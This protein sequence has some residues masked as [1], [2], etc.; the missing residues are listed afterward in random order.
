MTNQYP[1]KQPHT[2][3]I[4]LACSIMIG[5]LASPTTTKCEIIVDWTRDYNVRD[6]PSFGIR[7][8]AQ[9]NAERIVIAGGTTII[10]DDQNQIHNNWWIGKL[11][12]GLDAYEWFRSYGDSLYHEHAQKVLILNDEIA[13]LG[14]RT[15]IS[16]ASRKKLAVLKL[17]SDGDSLWSRTL[18]QGNVFF[19]DGLTTQDGDILLLGG[20]RT[21]QGHRSFTLFKL[22]EDG[23][24][25]W[26]RD[27]REQDASYNASSLAELQNSDYLITGYYQTNEFLEDNIHR[28]FGLT[29]RIDSDGELLWR[30]IV[31]D[32]TRDVD[33]YVYTNTASFYRSLEISDGSILSCG[34]T[35]L[36]GRMNVDERLWLVKSDEDGVVE[37]SKHYRN[38]YVLQTYFNQ[39]LPLMDDQLLLFGCLAI[40]GHPERS[41]PIIAVTDLDGNII[42]SLHTEVGN[43]ASLRSYI[44]VLSLDSTTFLALN[45]I[46]KL[47]QIRIEPNVEVAHD[48]YLTPTS[49]AVQAYPNPFNSFT[50]IH[51]NLTQTAWV[52]ILIM[53]AQGRNVFEYDRESLSTGRHHILI[54]GAE[55]SSGLYFCRVIIEE[56]AYYVKLIKLR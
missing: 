5:I 14:N 54:Q 21:D 38:N 7:S 1:R 44:D 51:F 53:D 56:T 3:F 50:N 18:G 24:S 32:S 26:Q 23:D 33:G 12:Q 19:K 35:E 11:N 20:T 42:D 37:W 52:S 2:C 25:L 27:Y 39:I 13:L 49:T 47:S 10:Y 29:M 17:S 55:L 15:D 46:N 6:D 16:N 22:T 4:L 31:I 48:D 36:S 43:S 28:Q 34:K 30:N 8:F 41:G 9:D 40:E 45:L